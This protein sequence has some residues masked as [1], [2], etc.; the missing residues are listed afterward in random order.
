MNVLVEKILPRH[1]DG[2]SSRK[3]HPSWFRDLRK[4][5]TDIHGEYDEC[6]TPKTS[7]SVLVRLRMRSLQ[8]E[9]AAPRRYRYFDHEVSI[10]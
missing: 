6:T 1:D 10:A 9:V 4:L 5:R 8:G 2:C 3:N 7:S